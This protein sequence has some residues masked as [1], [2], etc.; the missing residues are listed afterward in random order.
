[1]TTIVYDQKARQIAMDGRE[2]AG[3]EIKSD[4]IKKSYMNHMDGTIYFIA[5][6]VHDAKLFMSEDKNIGQKPSKSI[7]CTAIF[8]KEG[9]AYKGRYDDEIG[10]WEVELSYSD[11]IG[12][13]GVYA[14]CASDFGCSA[15]ES[16]EYASK[17]DVYTGGKIT[18]YDI[19]SGEFI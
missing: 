11:A 8:V 5:G 14:L 3:A 6:S 15:K 13:G 1:M 7:E 16:V 4:S 19:E 10:Y 2:V 12:T 18:V 9:K 17:R